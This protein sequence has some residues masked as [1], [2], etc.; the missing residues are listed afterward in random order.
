[1]AFPT[2]TWLRGP[3]WLRN[4]ACTS[5]TNTELEGESS[6]WSRSL[7]EVRQLKVTD[8]CFWK[9]IMTINSVYS[10]RL[11]AWTIRFQPCSRRARSFEKV[12]FI[13]TYQRGVTSYRVIPTTPPKGAP[14]D[15]PDTR[16]FSPPVDI[17]ESREKGLANARLATSN[18][19]SR[20]NVHNT[21]APQL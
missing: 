9:K 11:S 19:S 17:R 5:D 2:S 21:A 8:P 16:P 15:F 20:H 14:R 18:D 1:M 12:N 4:R 7:P 3:Y 6:N 13:S 10:N